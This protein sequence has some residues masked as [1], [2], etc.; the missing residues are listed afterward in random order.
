MNVKLFLIATATVALAAG[1]LR[2]APSA[3]ILAA[4]A[5]KGR[6]EAD[7]ARDE[8]R[9]PAE[10]LD[11]AGVTPGQTVVDLLPGAGY[12]TRIFSKAVGPDGMVFAFE[13][14]S[15]TRPS[16]V[17][18]LAA[19]PQYVNITVVAKGVVAFAIPAKADLIWTSQNYHDLKNNDD[20]DPVAF[21]KAV[22]DALKPG[23]VYI[24]LDHA[25]NAGALDATSTLHRV[26]P[27]VVR[28][29]VEAAGFK[30]VG[31]S[32]VLRN[33]QDD[34]TTGVFET[35]IRGRTDK[36]IYKFIK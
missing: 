21:N 15:E 17:G 23:G 11:F 6:P 22:H 3:E 14:P 18:P 8:N 2:A 34:R 26:D 4:V 33:P 13:P 36:F 20:V 32:T 10:M 28:Q 1:A 35:S 9:K 25:A 5:D 27:A 7:T 12:F 30:Y 19:D 31:E 29:E 16:R 24:V